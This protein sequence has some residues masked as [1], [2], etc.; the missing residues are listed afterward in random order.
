MRRG[1]RN[2]IKWPWNTVNI[3][4]VTVCVCV[5][6]CVI[7]CSC[8]VHNVRKCLYCLLMNFIL[9]KK[10]VEFLAA[11]HANTLKT[12]YSYLAIY[13][14]AINLATSQMNILVSAANFCV[15]FF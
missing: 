9:F 7:V 13:Q 2:D 3:L 5:C 10:T 12:L 4:C 8:T 11:Q 14:S 1:A 15:S 6:V